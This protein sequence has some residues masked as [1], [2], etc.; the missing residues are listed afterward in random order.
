MLR[1]SIPRSPGLGHRLVVPTMVWGYAFPPTPLIPQV[2]NKVRTENCK[3][4]LVAPARPRATWFNQLLQL[5]VD[6]PRS[7]P[8]L[9]SLLTQPHFGLRHYLPESLALHPWT[10]SG[11]PCVIRDF[12]RGLPSASLEQSTGSIYDAKWKVFVAW[13]SEHEI[14]P[15]RTS[16]PHLHSFSN[17]K[18]GHK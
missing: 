5:L 17:T 9:P 15:L 7:L 4:I 6:V 10:L 8:P 12:Q 1:V 2:L 14:D 13:C 18:K 11:R 16:V 3:I